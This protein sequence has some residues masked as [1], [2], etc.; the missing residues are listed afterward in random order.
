[1]QPGTPQSETE[2]EGR[3]RRPRKGQI[4]TTRARIV[5]GAAMCLERHG[6]AGASTA[7]IAQLAGTAEATVFRH[8]PRKSDVVAA[9]AEHLLAELTQV[10]L[11]NA[12]HAPRLEKRIAVT[13]AA[14]WSAF[15]HPRMGALFDIY[16][17]ARTDRALDAALEPVLAAHREGILE[18]ARRS[19]P[20][21]AEHADFELMI[22]TVVYSMQGMVISMFG[23]YD[24]GKTLRTFQRMA[25]RE[26][27]RLV[28]EAKK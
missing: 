2:T 19:F 8:F 11:V 16:V 6:Y 1:M 18:I 23:E 20:E 13:V 25:R 3:K 27:E 9:A 21:V 15:R 17:G 7:A 26:F 22:D 14:L 4:N 24:D 10:F 5:R 12:H 28:G